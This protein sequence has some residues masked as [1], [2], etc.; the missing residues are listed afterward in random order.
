LASTQINDFFTA[1]FGAS[2]GTTTIAGL[3]NVGYYHGFTVTAPDPIT[4]RVKT[5]PTPLTTPHQDAVGTI[6]VN[7]KLSY[8]R[9]RAVR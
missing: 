4:G 9:R 3:Y 5:K 7:P 1:V 8:Q 2:S 6:T